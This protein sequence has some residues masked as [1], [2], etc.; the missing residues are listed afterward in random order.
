MR[1]TTK[2]FSCVADPVRLASMLLLR[3]EGELCVC[4]LVVALDTNQ[5]KVSR[6]LA[7]LRNCSLVQDRRQGQW[8]HYSL[9]ADLPAWA[10]ATLDLTA[11]AEAQS[12]K[13][14]QARLAA[15]TDRPDRTTC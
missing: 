8:I 14:M 5:S 11:E 7:Q 1:Q 3:S 2:F 15:M 10:L 12:L 13:A 9:H 4:E 6:H